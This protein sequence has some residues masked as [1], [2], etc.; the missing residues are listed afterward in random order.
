MDVSRC[1]RK[2][3]DN[4]ETAFATKLSL[5]LVEEYQRL[6]DNYAKKYILSGNAM[7]NPGLTR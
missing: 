3:L 7:A 6:I 5:R 4:T 1:R 2:K